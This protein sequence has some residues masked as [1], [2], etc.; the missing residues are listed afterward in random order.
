MRDSKGLMLGCITKTATV[1]GVTWSGGQCNI[2][3]K[4]EPQVHVLAQLLFYYPQA[5]L[6]QSLLP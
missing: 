6:V 5:V 1:I 3:A 4:L 2:P